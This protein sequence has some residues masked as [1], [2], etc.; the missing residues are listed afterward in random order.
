MFVEVAAKLLH[1][2]KMECKVE[3]TVCS[4][5]YGK[6]LDVNEEIKSQFKSGNSCCHSV[7]NLWSPNLL[8]K[9]TKIE[10]YRNIISLNVFAGVKLGPSH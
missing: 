4:T 2:V 10:M 8:S 7:Q 6:P 9:H 3:L 1:V 5:I